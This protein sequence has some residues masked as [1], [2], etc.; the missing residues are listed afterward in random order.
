MLYL[1]H[2]WHLDSHQKDPFGPFLNDWALFGRIAELEVLNGNLIR[3]QQ[4][5]VR[6]E[7]VGTFRVELSSL[8]G[9]DVPHLREFRD[10]NHLFADDV[11]PLRC[12]QELQQLP[13]GDHLES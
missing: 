9:I 2:R 13:E 6:E 8:L 3:T 10:A 11:E 12:V 7:D 1:D 5:P 4:V